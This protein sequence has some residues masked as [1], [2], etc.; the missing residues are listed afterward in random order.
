MRRE[1]DFNRFSPKDNERRVDGSNPVSGTRTLFVFYLKKVD[2]GP[3]QV[4][5]SGW[6]SRLTGHY[7]YPRVFFRGRS[8]TLVSSEEPPPLRPAHNFLWIRSRSTSLVPS[9]EV[10]L[11]THSF[12]PPLPPCQPPVDGETG[13]RLFVGS[14]TTSG[15]L[16]GW[17]EDTSDRH[18]GGRDESRHGS[19]P[20]SLHAKRESPRRSTLVGSGNPC[21]A[22]T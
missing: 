1:G 11:L 18:W 13:D 3:K 9:S 20:T 10:P 7:P 6:R 5:V 2:P 19:G 21:P 16:V 4:V 8:D 22:I 12:T 17:T 14:E 15:G